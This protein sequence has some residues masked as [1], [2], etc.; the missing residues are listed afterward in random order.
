MA[1]LT[2]A[3]RTDLKSKCKSAGCSDDQCNQVE[4]LLGGIDVTKIDFNALLALILQIIA[5]FR[6]PAPAPTP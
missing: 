5:I 3:Q 2:A 4:S 6:P 1:N